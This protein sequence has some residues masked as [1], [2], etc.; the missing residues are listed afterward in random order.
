MGQT[1]PTARRVTYACMPTA[2]PVLYEPMFLV[3][4]SVPQDAMGGCYGVLSG[5][6]GMVFSEE[7]RVGTPMM[8]LKAYLPVKEAFG[9]DSAL[10]PRPAARRSPSAC[11][12][13]GSPLR[14]T[15]SMRA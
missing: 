14:A 8:N 11:S 10:R 4:I 6:R 13:T 7:Q 5:R 9:F 2:S 3:D 15:A 12:T 1:M